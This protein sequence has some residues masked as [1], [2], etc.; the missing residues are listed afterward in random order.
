M[1]RLRDVQLREID[2]GSNGK[3]WLPVRGIMETFLS[4]VGEKGKTDIQR[5]KSPVKREEVLLLEES[6]RLNQGLTDE[7]FQLEF[8]TGVPVTDVPTMARAGAQLAQLGHSGGIAPQLVARAIA[9]AEK[10]R[11]TL[12]ATST[13]RQRWSGIL[14]F[15]Y[16]AVGIA[17]VLLV[18]VLF[19][20]YRRG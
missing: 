8:P 3:I 17:M 19:L 16:V 5:Q 1:R 10:Q 7:R 11:A 20:W 9:D 14:V 15:G 2:A 18:M 6:V 13:A 4:D 12:E